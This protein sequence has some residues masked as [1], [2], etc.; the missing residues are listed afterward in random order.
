MDLNSEIGDIEN[1]NNFQ[2][3][4]PIDQKPGSCYWYI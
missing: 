4:D 2:K 1:E 3:D